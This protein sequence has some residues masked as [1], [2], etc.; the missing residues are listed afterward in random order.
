MGGEKKKMETK[1][2]VIVAGVALLIGISLGLLIGTV[3]NATDIDLSQITDK[4][5]EWVA[6]QNPPYVFNGEFYISPYSKRCFDDW[7]Q[8]PPAIKRGEVLDI[9]YD[10]EVRN[11]IAFLSISNRS[12]GKV[13]YLAKLDIGGKPAGYFCTNW[14]IPKD[15]E[16]GFYEASI[17]VY[18]TY[19]PYS[20]KGKN[21]GYTKTDNETIEFEIY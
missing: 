4:T 3:M 15:I 1:E 8:N 12:S 13:V 19:D 2:I 16:K 11:D 17:E 5:E 21:A 10:G 9:N 6:A 20:W 18:D 7:R 14:R